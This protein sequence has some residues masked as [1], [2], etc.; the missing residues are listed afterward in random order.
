MMTRVMFVYPD[1]KTTYGMFDDSNGDPH[2]EFSGERYEV[3]D[4]IASGV[5]AV[6]NDK[7]LA[8][9]FTDFGMKC[10]STPKQHTITISVKEE[11]QARLK[12]ASKAKGRTV[13]GILEE[14]ALK[15]LA[16]NGM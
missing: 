15:W 7:T 9:K 3:D 12:A 4:V 11:T 8:A 16:K 6:V 13:S 5:I 2:F 14:L 10:R 1:G